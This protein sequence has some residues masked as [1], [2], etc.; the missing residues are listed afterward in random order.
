MANPQIEEAKS[1][2]AS[3]E[4]PC[5]YLDAD[6]VLSTD[7]EVKEMTGE[8]EEILAAKNM[9][10]GKKLNRILSRCTMAIGPYRDPQMID[11][12]V[13]ELTQGDRVYLLFAIR[14]ASLGN[15]MPFVTKCLHCD[16]DSNLTI[17]LSE[18]EIKKMAD[19]MVRTYPVVLP[20]SKKKVQMK[21]LTGHGEDRISKAAQSDKDL[22][23]NAILARVDN[24]DGHPATI[25]ELKALSLVDR[26]FLRNVW[27]D[28]EGGVETEV[29]VTCPHCEKEYK[30]SVDLGSVG[31]FNPLALSKA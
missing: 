23:S 15:D 4:L 31:F 2:V 11:K 18:L 29:D 12:I 8:E 10:A 14:R 7:V 20:K 13:M 22:I 5:G 30:S 24:I 17:D 19:P 16:Q 1:S 28:H 27:E 21:V 25:Q 9:P 26:N 6:N 3:F